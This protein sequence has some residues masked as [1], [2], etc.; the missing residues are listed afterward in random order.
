[1]AGRKAIVV[2]G[3]MG[4]VFS[5]LY[6][7][8]LGWDVRIFE[9]SSVPLVG[10]GAGIVTH[11]E[12][13]QALADLGR[14]AESDLGVPIEKRIAIDAQGEVFAEHPRRQI[15]TSWNRL[16]E[17]L[18]EVLPKD[19]YELGKEF[20]SF[21]QDAHSI[22]ARFADGTSA[23]GD[24]LVGADGFR[25]QVRG[26]LTPE[27]K[28][29]FAGYVGWRGLADEA[30]FTPEFRRDV[31]D[32]FAFHL[33]P[34][35]QIIGY[36]AAG[37]GNDLRP[38]HRS[39]NIVWYRPTT[40][41]QLRRFLTDDTGHEHS[42][43]IPPPLISRSVIAEMRDI[44]ERTLPPQFREAIRIIDQP[45][46]QPIYDFE[47]PTMAVGRA[48]IIGD[49]AFVVRPHVG[50]GVVKAAQDAEAIARHVGGGEDV[51]GA[52][53]AFDAERRPIGAAFVAHV[54]R[55]GSYIKRE[56]ASEAE[57]SY[58]LANAEP[59]RVM[60]ET[61]VLDFM[62]GGEPTEEKRAVSGA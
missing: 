13:R 51:I 26:V 59:M 18:N 50:A 62:T 44:A 22:T 12:L 49:A 4:G 35:E 31:F 3:S 8:R 11:P 17:I 56:F 55:L 1:M 58:A 20:V 38:G 24:L 46:F 10:R 52:L 36:P 2:G 34:G 14:A 21:E 53:R 43:S 29:V 61:A 48:C 16:F 15:S 40:A 5:A 7:R 33:P 57:R 6:L 28:P 42:V 27:A 32:T 9:R 54:R 37:P 39:W 19:I 60:V 47:A 25:S 23:T 30:R 41:E 45:F